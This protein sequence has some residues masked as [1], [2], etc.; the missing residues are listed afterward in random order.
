MTK[1]KQYFQEMIAKNQDLFADFKKIHDLFAADR[2][3]YQDQ[4]NT[5]GAVVNEVIREWEKRLCLRMERI[6]HTPA[7]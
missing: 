7:I 3:K 6:V 4:Y 2:L 1:Y 5:Q